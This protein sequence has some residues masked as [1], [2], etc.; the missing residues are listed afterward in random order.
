MA[1]LRDRIGDQIELAVSITQGKGGIG[2]GDVR[3]F[4][5]LAFREILDDIREKFQLIGQV[6]IF[7]IVE[8]RK[9]QFKI[10]KFFITPVQVLRGDR[11]PPMMHKINN[12]SQAERKNE[13]LKKERGR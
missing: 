5:G 12:S 4:L 6:R 13:E 1:K 11:P 8:F 9:L 7:G 3:K 10:R 2:D